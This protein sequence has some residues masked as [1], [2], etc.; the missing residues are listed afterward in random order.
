MK[1][2]IFENLAFGISGVS[3]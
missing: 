2:L 1:I 3:A